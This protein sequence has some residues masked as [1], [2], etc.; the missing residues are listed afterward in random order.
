[1]GYLVEYKLQTISI[2]D[3]VINFQ[4]NF[5]GGLNYPNHSEILER[6]RIDNEMCQCYDEKAFRVAMK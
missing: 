5:P 1:M 4:E 2:G 6:V 3:L